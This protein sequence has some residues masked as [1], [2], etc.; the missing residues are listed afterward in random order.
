MFLGDVIFAQNN[1]NWTMTISGTNG[2]VNLHEIVYTTTPNSINPA[3][4]T[5]FC[6]TN[7]NSS[8]NEDNVC[9][10]GSLLPI[11][12]SWATTS[13]RS[14]PGEYQ[15]SLNITLA[16]NHSGAF[17]TSGSGTNIST[18]RVLYQGIGLSLPPLGQWYLNSSTILHVFWNSTQKRAC[19]GL[20]IN[21]SNDNEV[22]A[23]SV[24]GVVWAWWKV[25]GEN[26]GCEWS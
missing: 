5:G 10:T 2:S 17:N 16:S 9:F 22:A 18:S 4:F 1:P 8:T 23:W 15:D 6:R 13:T 14:H 7:P 20:K 19:D 26:G 24:L 11:D 25:W 3:K 21:L 12:L